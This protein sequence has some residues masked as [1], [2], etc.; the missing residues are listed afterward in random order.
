MP[1]G[2][3]LRNQTLGE[4]VD[5]DT[6]RGYV[7]YNFGIRFYES[8]GQT[9]E[10]ACM[11]LGLK[12]EPILTELLCIPSIKEDVL[13]FKTYPV[14]LI[15]E[16]LKHS[17]SVFIKN[18]LPYIGNLVKNFSATHADYLVIEKDLKVLFPL[19]AE[20]FIQHIYHEE[21]TLFTYIEQLENALQGNLNYGHMYFQMEKQSLQTF[22][23][24]HEVHDDEMEGI[25]RITR[26][27]HLVSDVPLHIKVIYHELIQFEKS[28]QT[29]AQIENEILFPKAML[30]ESQVRNALGAK[31]KYN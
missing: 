9:L 18:K 25:R 19:F 22:A 20:D 23:S 4:L 10:D 28:L 21:D 13:K 14:G 6:A 1:T 16:Y 31:A 27:Y 8:S 24:E 7:L 26:D 30:L 11:Q 3:M 5:Q 29:H 12:P 17:H 15:I 2:T